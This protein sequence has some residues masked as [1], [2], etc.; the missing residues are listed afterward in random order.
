LVTVLAFAGL[1]AM[2]LAPLA[3]WHSMLADIINSFHWSFTYV[4]SE[5][6]PWFLLL[7]GIAFFVPVAISAGRS[8]ES[9]LYPRARRA[10]IAWGTVVYLMGLILAVEVAAVW[11][12]AH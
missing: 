8:P 11:R 4:L 7:A 10:Y 6:S 3:I 1:F 2:T 5:L 9:R 12:Y